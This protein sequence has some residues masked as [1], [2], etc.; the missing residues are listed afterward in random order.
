MKVNV[1]NEQQK[2]QKYLKGVKDAVDFDLFH[3]FIFD[4][5]NFLA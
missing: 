2:Q 4:N 3:E 5:Q 1:S